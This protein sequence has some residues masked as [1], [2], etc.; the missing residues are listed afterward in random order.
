MWKEDKRFTIVVAS[1]A[2]IYLLYHWQVLSSIQD[3]AVKISNDL[4]NRQNTVK[5][6]LKDGVVSDS[7]IVKA[8]VDI[9]HSDELLLSMKKDIYL[10]V[11]NEFKLPKDEKSP[12]VYFQQTLL[13][14]KGNLETAA[15]KKDVGMPKGESLG[16]SIDIGE[17]D[18]SEML[19][20]LGI[21]EKVFRRAISAG[22]SNITA[23]NPVYNVEGANWQRGSSGYKKGAFLN[24]FF[25]EVKLNGTSESIFRLLHDLQRKNDFLT[26]R[27]FLIKK[28]DPTVD[29][30]Q[31]EI[32]AGGLIIDEQ[33]SPDVTATAE[34]E[35]ETPQ[36]EQDIE[37]LFE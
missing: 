37:K 33:G 22:V 17:K 9:K 19:K 35:S 10:K 18:S 36:E 1:M 29:L 20:R 7:A 21:V 3:E 12:R 34:E 32:V 31:A 11:D 23:I 27:K 2:V 16:F 14:A 30:L 26:I 8:E 6:L 28:D 13:K 5:Q 4:V 24:A 25:V 15:V